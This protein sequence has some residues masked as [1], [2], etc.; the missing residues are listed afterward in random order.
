MRTALRASPGLGKLTV[1][2][3]AG[4]F[5]D[6]MFQAA[7]SGAILFNP[8]RETDPLAVAAGFAVLLLPY[9][10]LGPYAGAMLDR[11]DRRNVLLTANLL[12][13]V[14]ICAAAGLVAAGGGPTALLLLALTVIGISRFVLAGASAAL[15]HVVRPGWLIP[16]NSL[17]ATAAAAFGGVG[18]AVAVAVIGLLGGGDSAGAVAVLGAAAGSLLSALAAIRFRPGELGP[19]RAGAIRSSG[20][21]GFAA[22]LRTGVRAVWSRPGVTT[23]LLGI[24]AHRVLFGIDTLI[25]VL[26]LRQHSADTIGGL[27]G[28]G[29]AIAAA[30]AGMLFA[31]VVA[32]LLIPRLGRSRTVV[33]GLLLAA[34]SQL[35]LVSQLTQPTLL[36]GAALLGCTGQLVKLTGDAALQLEV[37]DAHRGRVFA[38]Q[39]TVFNGAFVVALTGAALLV[40]ADGR[41]VGLVVAGAGVVGLALLAVAANE[42][43][44]GRADRAPHPG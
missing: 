12:R 30:A 39:D 21:A 32:P 41:S 28:F 43:S 17:F 25:M 31:A 8:E 9:S 19:D 5:G 40:P 1:I 2:R 27:V 38:L 10:I 16:M 26:V 20:W 4:Q 33:A 44:R 42:L 24:G 7:L 11:W 15:P 18:A 29:V 37:D 23:A 34:V 13:A 3:F 35:T 14:L 22:G 6:G 36:A